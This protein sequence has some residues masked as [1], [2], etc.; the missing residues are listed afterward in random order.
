MERR[1]CI[2]FYE[3]SVNTYEIFLV[4]KNLSPYLGIFFS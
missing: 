4:L 2:H 1:L 3:V